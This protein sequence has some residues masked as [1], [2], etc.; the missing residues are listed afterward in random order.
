MYC[1]LYEVMEM[2]KDVKEK[3]NDGFWM[4]VCTVVCTV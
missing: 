2:R 1:I 4:Y 3:K